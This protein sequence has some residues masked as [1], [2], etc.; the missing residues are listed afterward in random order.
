MGQGKPQHGT[1]CSRMYSAVQSNTSFK[2]SSPKGC[3]LHHS[4]MI[5]SPHERNV[6][7]TKQGWHPCSKN[8]ILRAQQMDSRVRR[9]SPHT[10]LSRFRALRSPLPSPIAPPADYEHPPLPLAL[11]LEV[12]LRVSLCLSPVVVKVG[13]D[14][15]VTSVAV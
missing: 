7:S 12:M 10:P 2:Y 15:E 6:A 1:S 9:C 13:E 3:K 11:H 5:G 4:W 14:D 8:I